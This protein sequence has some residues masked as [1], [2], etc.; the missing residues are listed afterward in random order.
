ML[1]LSCLPRVINFNTSF[2][3]NQTDVC[4]P[5]LLRRYK[6][7]NPALLLN[8]AQNMFELW[9]KLIVMCHGSMHE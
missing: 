7:L 5:F 3:M 1:E 9:L 8:F 6:P 4:E 2:L